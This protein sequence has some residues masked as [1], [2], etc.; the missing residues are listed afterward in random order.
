MMALLNKTYWNNSLIEWLTAAAV[1]FLLLI[2]MRL[3]K[4]A[5]VRYLS[6]RE[7]PEG[8]DL[9]E[10]TATMARRTKLPFII[11]FALWAGLQVLRLPEGLRPWI[12]SITLG[13]YSSFAEE[14]IEFAYPT[15]TLY[16]AGENRVE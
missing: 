15:R 3:V 16:I 14:G 6:K 4:W 7:R 10:L 2:A 13:I 8:P 5:L 1:A 11:I 9:Y 12:Y